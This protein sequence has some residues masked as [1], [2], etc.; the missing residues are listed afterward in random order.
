MRLQINNANIFLVIVS[1]VFLFIP[2]IGSLVN[3]AIDC[4]SAYYL[5]MVER[6][7][8]G[9]VPYKSLALGYTPLW[10]YIMAGIKFIFHIPY[11]A[12][13]IYLFIHY[14][15]VVGVS[16]FLYKIARINQVSS[17]LSV[18]GAGLFILMSHWMQ[19]NII[20]LEIPS[21]FWGLMSAYY[22]FKWKDS[23]SYKFIFIGIMAVSSFLTKQFGLGFFVLDIFLLLVYTKCKYSKVVLFFIGYFLPLLL[24]WLIW[25]EAFVSLIFS[26]YGTVSAKQAGWDVSSISKLSQILD[27]LW[28]FIRRV[29]P[30]LLLI[31][32]V[33]IY[34]IRRRLPSGIMILWC[35][36]GILGFALQFYFVQ[37]GLHYMLYMLPFAVLYI[38]FVLSLPMNKVQKTISWSLLLIVFCFSTYS[39]YRNRVFKQYVNSDQKKGQ[40]LLAEQVKQ[41]LL[42]GE[43]LW[44]VHGGLYTVYYLANVLP[45][46]IPSIGYSFGPL[47]INEE[48]A[49]S[50]IDAADCILRFSADYP[51]ESFFTERLKK[52]VEMIPCIVLQDSVVLLHKKAFDE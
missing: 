2:I 4:D 22:I 50:Q 45:P 37:G 49:S 46:N 38:V 47:G 17:H 7:A 36:L 20:L 29:V 42:K 13:E 33:I 3:G 21:V 5:L 16:F 15:F 43:T 31:P 1:I 30:F 32:I 34:I 11:G 25:K 14:L 48:E 26:D 18:I 28:F 6:I 41:N 23:D 9:Y 40:V 12:Y 52:Q 8:E 44:I 10:F 24:C 39:T 35:I 19:G 51:Y 27:N